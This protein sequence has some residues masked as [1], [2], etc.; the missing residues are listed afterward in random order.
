MTLQTFTLGTFAQQGVA[1]AADF[2]SIATFT[3]GAGGVSTVTFSSIPSTY[4]HLQLRFMA[5]VSGATTLDNL[6]MRFNNTAGTSYSTHFL[7]GD[8]ANV[9][10]NYVTISGSEL[11][12]G[13]LTGANS[14]SG[15]FGVGVI[16]ILDYSNTN[17]LKATRSLSGQDQ[18]GS[19][20]AYFWSGLFNSTNA[21]TEIKLLNNYAEYSHFALYG[22]KAA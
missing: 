15:R 7:Q 3:V 17:K 6:T 21:I 19:G 10:S 12:V 2:D 14:T 18:N 5:R 22:I 1:A 16:D 9:T 11:Y 4:A 20:E 13:R 8:G